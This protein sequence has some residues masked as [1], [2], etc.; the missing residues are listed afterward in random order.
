MYTFKE[1]SNLYQLYG[2]IEK[3]NRDIYNLDL[4]DNKC[5]ENIKLGFNTILYKVYGENYKCILLLDIDNVC[6]DDLLQNNYIRP[7]Y[8]ELL[9]KLNFHCTLENMIQK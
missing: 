5:Y 2:I 8:K 3:V 6:Y 7:C 1:L 4:G 9:I